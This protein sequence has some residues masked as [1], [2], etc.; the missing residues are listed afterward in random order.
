MSENT[1]FRL[2]FGKNKH[3]LDIMLYSYHKKFILNIFFYIK[4]K[5]FI[6]KMLKNRKVCVGNLSFLTSHHCY[7]EIDLVMN[8]YSLKHESLYSI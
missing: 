6:K 8:G 3:L 2:Y 4:H 1:I 5:L 7:I